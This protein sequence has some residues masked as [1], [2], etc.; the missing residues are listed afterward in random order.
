MATTRYVWDVVT[1][2]YLMEKD[3]GGA[4]QVVYETTP[5]PFGE[6]VSEYRSGS[7]GYFQ[8]DGQHSARLLADANADTLGVGVYLGYGED[9]V[10]S[11]PTP[12][13]Y[14]GAV[15]YYTDEET[16]D[17]YVRARTYS[18]TQGRWLSVDPIYFAAGDVNLYRYVRNRPTRDTDASGKECTCGEEIECALRAGPLRCAKARKCANDAFAAA[19]KSQLPGPHNGPQDAY[20]HCVWNCCMARQISE[21]YAKVIADLHEECGNNPVEEQSMDLFNNDIGRKLGSS[22]GSWRCEDACMSAFNA[23]GLQTS[24]GGRAKPPNGDYPTYPLP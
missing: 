11:M 23:G 17:V 24:P 5:V 18:P 15:G 19:R 7:A 20:R 16:E 8:N 4:T 9:I 22:A 12:F 3:G 10:N 21:H 14:K 6:M 13:Q 1:D 2:S